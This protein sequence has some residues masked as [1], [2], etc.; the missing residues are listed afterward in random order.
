MRL[1]RLAEGL[2]HM[3][4]RAMVPSR[5][6][7]AGVSF[8][9]LSAFQGL[10]GVRSASAMSDPPPEPSSSSAASSSEIPA[11]LGVGLLAD[12]SPAGPPPD[13]G[14][15]MAGDDAIGQGPP[16]DAEPEAAAAEAGDWPSSGEVSLE[17]RAFLPDDRQASQ[18]FNLG[19][20]ARVGVAHEVG[21][22]AFRA[23]AY[24]RNDYSDDGRS[25]LALEELWLQFSTP[26]VVARIGVDIF[27][28]S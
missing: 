17:S 5:A 2:S 26:S 18:D 8:L 6:R 7:V 13:L 19:L 15:L 9:V 1:D 21:G 28:W 10:G 23:R 4:L 3:P 25:L 11:D 20:F 24:G 27:N 22:L 16:R 12:E 14:G